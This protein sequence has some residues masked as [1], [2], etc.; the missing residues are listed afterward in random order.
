MQMFS[1]GS[2]A[3]ITTQAANSTSSACPTPIPTASPLRWGNWEVTEL[4]TKGHKRQ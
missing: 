3:G 2:F 4:Y 1:N